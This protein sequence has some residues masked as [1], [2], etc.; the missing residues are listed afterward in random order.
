MRI[1][2]SLILT[3]SATIFISAASAPEKTIAEKKILT[4]AEQLDQFLPLLKGKRVAMLANLTS[5]I[6]KTHL[7]DRMERYRYS[8][9][10]S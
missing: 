2:L 5:V 6:G 1:N 9:A 3:I 10:F 8:N 4:G 7:V